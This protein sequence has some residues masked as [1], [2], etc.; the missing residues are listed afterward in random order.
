[1]KSKILIAAVLSSVML[2]SCADDSKVASGTDNV[3]SAQIEKAATSSE[4]TA[5]GVRPDIEEI[6]K[7]KF[8]DEK[9][10]PTMRY[11]KSIQTV[12]DTDTTDSAAV[13]A[14]KDEHMQA[15]VCL[16]KALPSYSSDAFE[17]GTVKS[18]L[19]LTLNTDDR[20]HAYDDFYEALGS[21]LGVFDDSSCA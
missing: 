8:R 10:A 15:M 12:L 2:T 13:I 16:H 21:E 3:D 19:E 5:S 7:T 17:N 11:A 18:M 9:F 14:S 6:I 20:Q 4:L 1:M